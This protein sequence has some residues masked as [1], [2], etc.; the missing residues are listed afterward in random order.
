MYAVLPSP[1]EQDECV[2]VAA[3][4][5]DV[6]P[7]VIARR[8]EALARRC[9]R[10][11]SEEEDEDRC[12]STHAIGTTRRR[13][14]RSAARSATD[15]KPTSAAR[16]S[17]RYVEDAREHPPRHRRLD[18]RHL[19]CVAPPTRRRSAREVAGTA[20]GENESGA[21]LHHERPLRVGS[22]G[23]FSFEIGGLHHVE[24]A[25]IRGICQLALDTFERTSHHVSS[26]TGS[27]T[28]QPVANIRYA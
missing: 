15:E 22:E 24:P 27:L 11:G 10:A 1:A 16:R 2:A 17:K 18:R 13:G 7:H 12:E 19:F 21:R 25:V 20:L 9:V 26:V 8:D 3:P 28:P 6:Q 4:V 5:E 14:N 23:R